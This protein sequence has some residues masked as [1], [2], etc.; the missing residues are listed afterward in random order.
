MMYEATGDEELKRRILYIVDELEEIQNAHGNGYALAFRDGRK[1]FDEIASGKIMV[2][3]N[4]QSEYSAMI[5]GRFEPIYTMNKVLL[6]LY[7][8]W[9]ATKDAKVRRVFLRLSDWSSRHSR[10]PLRAIDARLEGTWDRASPGDCA[11]LRRDVVREGRE[12]RQG[13]QLH[14]QGAASVMGGRCI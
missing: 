4:K 10:Q 13:R 6:G 3:V 7:R 2:R 11:P 5:N 12:G 9:V 8:A 14:D 1:V